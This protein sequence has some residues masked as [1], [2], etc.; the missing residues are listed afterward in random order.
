MRILYFHQYFNTPEMSGSTR[1]Y[2][3]ARRL[4]AGGHRVDIVT[5][6]RGSGASSN[7]RES[8]CGGAR[9]HWIAVPYSNEL[10][11]ARRMRAFL[12]YALAAARRSSSIDA[13]LIFATSTP[14]TIALPAAYAKLRKRVPLIMEIRD[15]WPEVPIAMGVLRSRS[16][17]ALARALERF[18]YACSARVVALSPGM[19]DGVARAGYPRERVVTLPNACD[20]ELFDVP[21]SVG[22]AF[23][24]SHPWLGDRPLVVYAG[25]LGRANDVGFL[26]RLAGSM[27]WIDERVRFLVVGDG[28]EREDL[29]ALAAQLGVL[30]R[31]LFMMDPVP[32]LAMPRILAAADLAVSTFARVPALWTNSANKVFDA[33]ASGTPIAINHGGWIAELLDDHDAG[34]ILDAADAEAAARRLAA[35]LADGEWLARAATNARRLARDRFSRDRLVAQL[36]QLMREVVAESARAR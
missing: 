27:R 14:L 6:D 35:A 30:D 20:L 26:V 11:F 32:K 3:I 34:L 18:A 21:V 28:A 36:E 24:A 23:R 33:L 17:R 31:T 15:L 9:V 29:R 12:R 25:T 19:A 4:V 10:P 5:S 7:W 22:Q 16:S 13:D 2:E 1:S 8:E